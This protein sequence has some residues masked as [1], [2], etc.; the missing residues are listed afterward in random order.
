MSPTH[1]YSPFIAEYLEWA[2]G[3]NGHGQEA[4]RT[5]A[6]YNRSFFNK[7]AD[8]LCRVKSGH[9]VPKRDIASCQGTTVRFTDGTTAEAECIVTC[10]GYATA[11]P[12][13]DESVRAG[14][15][16]RKWFKYIFY[17]E[18]PS[19][20]FVGFARPVFGS[21]PGVAELAS[22][23][24]ARVF[25]GACQLPGPAE[26]RAITTRDADFW[27]HHFRDTSLRI[28]GLV[29]HFVYSNQLARL[30]GC[31]PKF[32]ALFFSSPRRWWQAVTAPWNGCQFWLNDVA[33]HDRVFATLRRYSDDRLAQGYFWLLIA[34]ILPLFALSRHLRIFLREHPIFTSRTW[35]GAV[36]APRGEEIINERA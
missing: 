20:A 15:D 18:D 24:V 25:S 34:P 11:F 22:R 5:A 13:L 14:T 19:L 3:F 33:H 6:S 21:I 35:R 17:N 30:I 12:F 26:R 36:T 29:D 4:W 27:N 7:S 1:R 16:P 28:A 2:L 9:V 10:S 32:W 8:V 23:Y 31:Y